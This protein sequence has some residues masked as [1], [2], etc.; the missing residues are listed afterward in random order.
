[1][2]PRARVGSAIDEPLRVHRLVRGK[3]ARRAR[4]RELLDLVGLPASFESRYPHELSG[5]ERQR[6]SIA[7]AL[8]GE[9]DLLILDEAT[10]SL[11][12]SV[13]A[14]VL[15]LL[16]ALQSEM[17]LTYLFIAH[18][19]AVVQRMSHDVLVMRDGEAVEY[20]PAA[21]LFADPREEYTR[22]LLAAVPP[23]R[24]RVST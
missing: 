19:L 23:E 1:L 21:D 9:P 18:D 7:R 13:Q 14:R 2:N 4:I 5:G 6:V 12:V 22:A 11:D 16:A 10:A 24:P 20:R 15:D 17:G 3:D 8:A